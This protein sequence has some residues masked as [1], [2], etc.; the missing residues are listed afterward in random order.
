[1]T[2]INFYRYFRL[3]IHPPGHFPFSS[4]SLYTIYAHG[5]S[6]PSILSKLRRVHGVDPAGHNH[7]NVDIVVNAV[8]AAFATHARVLDTTE[9]SIVELA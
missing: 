9:S 1:M 6:F 8:L 2:W 3:S 5:L 7:L 4:L